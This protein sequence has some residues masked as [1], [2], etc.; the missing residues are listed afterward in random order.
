M[1]SFPQYRP[2][3][4]RR[5]PALRA[6]VRE[7]HLSPS[8]LILPL[9]A[10]PGAGVRQPVSSM[11]GVFQTSVDELLL[12][13]R[14]A[15]EE[16]VGGV[17]LFGIPALFRRSPE[18]LARQQQELQQQQLEQQRERERF[19][20]VQPRVDMPAP[21]PPP[22]ANLSDLDRRA[23][24]PQVAPEAKNPEAFSRGNSVER[25][26]AAPAERARGEETP[27]PE[28]QPEAPK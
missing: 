10:R 13:A 28:A 11:P 22:R 3:R 23:T 24:A 7:T 19:V 2:R 5:T 12:D 4:L 16:G 21:K 20:F 14:A 17:L 27:A 9:F 18:E 6:L 1:P 25:A 8:Q 15:A 26:E